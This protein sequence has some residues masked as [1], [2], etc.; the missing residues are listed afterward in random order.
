MADEPA[1]Q[2]LKRARRVVIKIGSKTLAADQ[3]FYRRL[4]DEVGPL[5]SSRRSF[6]IVSSGAVALGMVKLGLRARP[7]DMA[8]IQASAAAGQSVLMR[9]YEEHFGAAGMAVAQVLLTHADLADRARANNA[10]AALAALLEAGVVPVINENDTVA[11]EE[12]RFG[13]NDQLAS[14][15]VPLVDADLLLLLSDVPGLLDGQKRVPLV[16]DIEREARPLAGASVS[17]VGTGGMASKVEAARR[18]TFAGANVVVADAREPGIVS[19]VC[20]GE[21]VGTLFVATPRRLS[22]RRHWVAFTLRPRGALVLD[23]GAAEAVT[24]RNKSLL[25]V[26]VTGVRGDFRAG[27]AVTLVDPA[28]R[29]LGRGLCRYPASEACRYAGRRHDDDGED[30]VFVHRDDLVVFTPNAATSPEA[31]AKNRAESAPPTKEMGSANRGLSAAA[32]RPAPK[33]PRRYRRS[34]GR[35]RPGPSY[36]RDGRASGR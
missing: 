16:R 26:G 23:G 8:W 9:R 24:G 19:A 10:R 17:G 22:A 15:V 5:Q 31:L 21:D 29:E 2:A 7:K 13:D 33:T 18:A 32:R 3:T 14:M 11:V 28:G 4:A 1:R 27:D 25:A 30:I 20:R 6:V 35:R 34:A 12:I 36:R